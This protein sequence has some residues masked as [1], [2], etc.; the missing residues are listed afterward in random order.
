MS[1]ELAKLTERQS[2][3]IGHMAV[4]GR[5]KTMQFRHL[6]FVRF[7]QIHNEKL[8]SLLAH[9]QHDA[10]AITTRL[11]GLN[12]RIDRTA[13]AQ[14]RPHGCFWAPEKHAMSPLIFC[15]ISTNT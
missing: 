13:V 9:N 2:R 11:Y 7:Q 12:R 1:L 4:F 5:P 8:F 14:D 10:C 6:F 3:N 15:S